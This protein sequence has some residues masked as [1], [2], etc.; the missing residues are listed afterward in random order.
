MKIIKAILVV[1]TAHCGFLAHSASA[2]NIVAVESRVFMPSQTPCSIGVFLTNDVGWTGFV[3]PL[4]FRTVSGLAYMVPG[5]FSR[6][7]NPT[8]RLANSPLGNDDPGGQWPAAGITRRTYAVPTA[9]GQCARPADPTTSW[10]TSAA[11]PDYVSPDAVFHACNSTGDP[12]IGELIVFEPGADPPGTANASYR[13]IFSVGAASGQFE[14]DTTCTRPSNTLVFTDLHTQP[15]KPVFVKGIVT[16]GDTSAGADIDLDGVLNGIDNCLF[17]PNADQANSDG[18]PFGD[19]CDACPQVGSATNLDS[20]YD[21]L[22][23]VCDNC[24]SVQNPTQSDSDAD[25]HGDACDH[26]P[27][28]V[29][30]SN[31]DSDGDELGDEC[32]NCPSVANPLQEDSDGDSFGTA[33]DN[34]PGDFNPS[35]ADD[36]ADGIGDV[37]DP[38]LNDSLNDTDGDGLCGLVDN[39]PSVANPS[40][41]DTDG[42]GDGNACDNCPTISNPNQLNSDS[43]TFGDACDNCPTVTNQT[44]QDSDGDGRGQP[45]D[46]CPSVPN[47]TQADLDFDG[48]GDACDNCPAVYNVTQ[49]DSD[50]D[51][52][53]DACDPCPTDPSNSCPC[54]C[55]CHADPQCDEA[56]DI[57]DVILTGNRAFRGAIVTNDAACTPHGSTVDGRT[58]VDCSG[59]TDI[60]DVVR[61]VDVAFRGVAPELRFC[62]PCDL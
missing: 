13:V 17:A 54:E 50:F 40:Q 16:V 44:Q 4:E 49:I 43:D 12:N 28:I 62:A 31:G 52:L 27:G 34:C 39:C 48:Y 3:L 33:C 59:A 6:D 60:V 45:C 37:C 36:D 10:N 47:L 38:C 7:H 53:G 25:G 32:D 1:A 42:D 30:V 55:L 58:D 14:I 8:G 56:T 26:C 11:L 21:G 5:V 35:Q 46:N 2:D 29:N 22:G 9:G 15:F 20:D 23:D 18:D 19:V 41:A 24:P 57:L 51:S 61:M